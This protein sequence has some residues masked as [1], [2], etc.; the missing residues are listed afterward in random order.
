MAG[1]KKRCRRKGLPGITLVELLVGM[2]IAVVLAGSL[3]YVFTVS[4]GGYRMEEEVVRAS[5]RLR[6]GLEQLKRDI[7][8][9]GFLA[10][11]DSQADDNVCPKPQN[12]LLGIY[13]ERIGDTYE[14]TTNV[15]IQPTAVTLFG[16]YPSPE[17]FFTQSIIGNVV[18]LQATPNFPS[19]KAEFDAIFNSN[20]LLRIVNSEQFEMYYP[21]QSADFATRTIVL[22]GAPPVSTPPDY[23][24][25]QGF[26]VGLEVN[27]VGY[28][29]YIVRRDVRSGAPTD[30][31]G[32]INKLDLV[33]EELTPDRQVVPGSRV[34]VAEYV[35]DLAFYDFAMDNDPTRTDPNLYIYPNIEDVV[36]NSGSGILSSAST[37]RPQDL[38][39]VTV[40]LSVRTEHEDPSLSMEKRQ[41]PHA[42]YERYDADV[43]MKGV[44]RVF[45]LASRVDLKAFMVRN[46][47]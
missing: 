25:I 11:P 13:F 36:N 17:V 5:E 19:T 6:F 22:S 18:T 28:I 7:A 40:V 14:P 32:T 42:P 26:G 46:V 16:A 39:F 21:I 12:R 33:R 10:T 41:G 37:S 43:T 20:H 1:L 44:A 29:R 45:H 31:N 24:G 9:A 27:A 4:V 30:G 35:T 3:Y 15:N 2:V 47:K 38:R 34:I 8:A 23:C